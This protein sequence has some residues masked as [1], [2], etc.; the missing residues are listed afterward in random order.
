VQLVGGML[1]HSGLV[2]RVQ[3]DVDRSQ[4][5]VIAH[6]EPGDEDSESGDDDSMV[7][8]ARG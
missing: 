3:M 1:R 7:E 6:G 2:A 8:I 5:W 4:Y